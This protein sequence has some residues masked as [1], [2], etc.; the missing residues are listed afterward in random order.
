MAILRKGFYD[1][2]EGQVWKIRVQ[3]NDYLYIG[4]ETDARLHMNDIADEAQRVRDEER[5]RK[6]K[7]KLKSEILGSMKEIKLNS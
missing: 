2:I 1:C 6:G 7:R 3:G 4:G 5:E